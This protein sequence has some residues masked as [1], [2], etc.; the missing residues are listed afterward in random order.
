M[1]RHT[2][3]LFARCEPTLKAAVQAVASATGRDVSKL[4]RAAVRDY[5][6]RYGRWPPPDPAPPQ[7]ESPTRGGDL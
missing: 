6:E 5:L 7:E 3:L 1:Q 2:A 4:V